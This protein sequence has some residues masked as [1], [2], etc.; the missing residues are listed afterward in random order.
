MP[1]RELLWDGVEL[2]LLGMGIVFTFL[3]LLV[4][5]LYSMS[6]IARR[7]ES[8]LDYAEPLSTLPMED[9]DPAEIAAV[10]AAVRRYRSRRR[11]GQP[12]GERQ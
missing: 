10:A 1:V 7:I 3:A 6:A 8:R 12:Q 11:A 5:A 4:V 9:S 2:M